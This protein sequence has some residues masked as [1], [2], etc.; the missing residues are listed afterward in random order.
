[1]PT[2]M[3]S[4]A[5]Q[6]EIDLPPEQAQEQFQRSEVAAKGEQLVTKGDRI[7]RID[8]SRLAEAL[9]QG[10]QL[11]DEDTADKIKLRREETD[12]ASLARGA[13][14]SIG[15]TLTFG[16]SDQATTA[17]EDDDESGERLGLRRE[18][19][20]PVG[21]ALELGTGLAGGLAGVAGKGALRLAGLGPAALSHTAT[22]VGAAAGRLV[23]AGATG[24]KVI[25]PLVAGGAFEGYVYGAAN[26]F[27]ESAIGEREI[28]AEKM[29]LEDGAMGAL[30]GGAIPAVL[31]GGAKIASG[32]TA[33]PRRA[34]RDLIEAL[35]DNPGDLIG[36]V[37]PSDETMRKWGAVTGTNE[38]ALVD[39]A[40]YAR[41]PEKAALAYEA[42]HN[43][44]RVLDRTTRE[45]VDNLQSFNSILDEATEIATGASK[46]R[47]VDSLMPDDSSFNVRGM[48]RQALLDADAILEQAQLK[49]LSRP[50]SYVMNDIDAARERF[51]QAIN[52][53]DDNTQFHISDRV[54]R[55]DRH[56]RTS[57]VDVDSRDRGFTREPTAADF[58]EDVPTIADNTRRGIGRPLDIDANGMPVLG[59]QA[60]P[61]QHN[62]EYPASSSIDSFTAANRAKQDLDIISR[63]RKGQLTHEVQDTQ[64]VLRKANS[65]LRKHLEREEVFAG[66]A[67]LQK[68]TNA[69]YHAM[70]NA[71]AELGTPRSVLGRMLDPNT[72][73][74]PGDALA[75]A[76]QYGKT[77][78]ETKVGK[79]DAALDARLAYIRTVAKHYELPEEIVT[80][81]E[82]AA[83]Q[84][85]SALSSKAEYADFLKILGKVRNDGSGP[86]INAFSS[87]GSLFGLAAAGPVGLLAGRALSSPYTTMRTLISLRHFADKAGAKVDGAIGKVLGRLRAPEGVKPVPSKRSAIA[88]TVAGETTENRKTARLE[89]L[90]LIERV[91]R[92]V[93]NPSLLVD[94]TEVPLFDVTQAAPRMASTIRDRVFNGAMY[95]A[96]NAPVIYKAPFD[97][98]IPPLYD[99]EKVAAFERRAAVV[100]NPMV[101][102]EAM[103]NNTMTTEHADALREVWPS[104]YKQA[105]ERIVE[106]LANASAEGRD[107]PFDARINIGTWLSTVTDISL[108][109]LNY[110]AIQAVHQLQ[111]QP[112]QAQP[113]RQYASNAEKASTKA[114]STSDVAPVSERM[115]RGVG[116]VGA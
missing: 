82:T 81:A 21:T 71:E 52:E 63:R 43:Y 51:A 109:P 44:D 80:R 66:G 17:L 47:R 83:R 62:S 64:D 53:L 84:Y 48:T 96:K 28:S 36:K 87:V 5:V 105:Q 69:A 56:V 78:G 32:A 11:T 99:E 57:D 110:S 74:S 14:E 3:F 8:A 107:I 104:I 50:G 46:L 112:Q 85:H 94:E 88:G 91:K 93:N 115:Q 15:R 24:T 22:R 23:P 40:N 26:E 65:V 4:P 13:V 98:K 97:N 37:V 38:E 58:I 29:L 100:R 76:K 54:G 89:T 16:L 33:L 111:A 95:L 25:A 59:R 55:R 60:K 72:P 39:I 106:E 34:A 114:V 9:E 7:L 75:L 77:A 73:V 79:I 35:P 30:L 1:M 18:G 103:Y 90:K 102:F 101:A 113:L 6:V 68:E 19:L 92:I 116:D 41:S 27:T 45:V 31:V 42:M 70:K 49:G 67:V 86:S 2:K 108:H 10:W 61:K 12:A 20:G